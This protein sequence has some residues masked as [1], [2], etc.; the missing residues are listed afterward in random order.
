MRSIPL[1]ASAVVSSRLAYGCWRIADLETGRAAVRAALEAGYTLFD[2][3][4]VYGLGVA[5]DVFGA[6]LRETPGMREQIQIAGK[7]GIRLANEPEGAPYRYDFSAEYIV[8]SCE[9]S[10]RRL[11]IETFD[12]YQLHR[13]D[14][15]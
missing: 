1:G 4:D 14:Y 10:L 11:G 7:C 8:W 3:A 13:P 9:Q 2:H 6:V 15:L 12:V 5:E